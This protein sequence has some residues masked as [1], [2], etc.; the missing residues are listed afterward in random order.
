LKRD[1]SSRVNENL[2]FRLQVFGRYQISEVDELTE[3]RM[4][5]KEFRMMKFNYFDF[6]FGV[7]HSLFDIL[8]FAFELLRTL[9]RSDSLRR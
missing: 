7:L 6:S 4:S 9:R 5:N 3:C 2:L 8:R 1:F